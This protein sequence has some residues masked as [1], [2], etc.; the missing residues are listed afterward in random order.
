M[1]CQGQ[2]AGLAPIKRGGK[3]K[4]EWYWEKVAGRALLSKASKRAVDWSDGIV[5]T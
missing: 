1:C 2:R 5:G 3:V 4:K